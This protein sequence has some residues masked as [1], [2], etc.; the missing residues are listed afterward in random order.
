[1]RSSASPVL[2]ARLALIVSAVCAEADDCQ[3]PAP[4]NVIAR[5]VNGAARHRS[6]A[7]LQA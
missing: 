3:R 2:A 5:R 4:A 7:K 1:M 6:G